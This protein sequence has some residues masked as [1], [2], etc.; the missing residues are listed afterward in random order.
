[1]PAA[2]VRA[3]AAAVAFLTRVPVGRMHAFDGADVARGALLFPLVGAGVG[4]ASG[5]VAIA[6]ESVLGTFLAAALAVATAVAL[7]G[8]MHVDALADTADAVGASTRERA[9]EMMRDPRVGSFGV[10]AVALDLVVRTA[11]TTQLLAHGAAFGALIAAGALSRALSP[12]LATLLPYPRAGGG[13]GSVLTHAVG[14]VG[15]VVAPVGAVAI[16]AAA[17]G[18]NGLVAAA[19]MLALGVA[20]CVLYRRWLGGATGDMLGAA[21][22]VSETLTLVVLVALT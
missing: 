12:P 20:A 22:Q 3:A 17:A 5:A 21:T 19:A 4:A 2:S 8:A 11:A 6:L 7:T 18:V 1:M 15:A 14:R 16:A 9:L 13:P 10:A